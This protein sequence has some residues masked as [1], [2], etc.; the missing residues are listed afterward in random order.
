MFGREVRMSIEVMLGSSRV[1][2]DEEVTSYGDYVETL[3][4]QMQRAHDV[5]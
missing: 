2:T 4:K 1:P 3:R 5:A